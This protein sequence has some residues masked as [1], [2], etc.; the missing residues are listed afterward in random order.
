MDSRIAGSMN[1]CSE[2]KY[3]CR[4]FIDNVPGISQFHELPEIMR[5]DSMVDE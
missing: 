4:Y 5:K 2:D 1:A 3:I